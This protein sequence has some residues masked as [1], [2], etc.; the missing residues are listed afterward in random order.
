MVAAPTAQR[1]VALVDWLSG[2]LGN[3]IFDRLCFSE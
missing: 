2:A 1:A 3:T